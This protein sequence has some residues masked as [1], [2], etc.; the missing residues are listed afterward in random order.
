MGFPK[1]QIFLLFLGIIPGAL[2]YYK[3]I[4]DVH[5]ALA[6]MALF[7]LSRRAMNQEEKARKVQEASEE[8][9]P[10]SEKLSGA[11]T[12]KGGAKKRK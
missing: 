1:V 4:S 10:E 9:V 7:V 3:V 2:F 11:V 8:E 6:L 5:A 12:K